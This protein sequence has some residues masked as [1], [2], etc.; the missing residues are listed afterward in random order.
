MR[1]TQVLSW[2]DQCW[3][4]DEVREAA[5]ESFVVG[6]VAGETTRPMLRLLLVCERH[7]KDVRA[8]AELVADVEPY[9]APAPPTTRR[10]GAPPT[11][12]DQCPLCDYRATRTPLVNHVWREHAPHATRPPVPDACPDCGHRGN[13]QQVGVHRRGAHGY[14]ALVE[15]VEAAARRPRGRPRKTP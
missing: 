6:I 1:E 2:C 5:V 12:T 3:R 4:E 8:L 9:A 11:G 15:A 7:A 10:V 14:D 13:A